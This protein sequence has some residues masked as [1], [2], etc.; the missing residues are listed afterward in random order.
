MAVAGAMAAALAPAPLSADPPRTATPVREAILD[1]SAFAEWSE[2]REAAIPADRAKNG[3]RDVVWT[4][5]Q[6]PDW[7]GVSFGL[8]RT[9]G[10]RHLRIG[11]KEAIAVGAVLSR[12]GGTLSVLKA[13]ASYPGDLANESAWLKA[14]RASGPREAVGEDYAFWTLPAGTKTRALRFSHV[15]DPTDANP[16]G[17]L[18][19]AWVLAERSANLAPQAVVTTTSRSESAGMLN[20]ESNN[21]MWPSWDNGEEGAALPVAPERPEFVTLTWPKPVKLSSLCLL[22]TGFRAADVEVFAG[23]DEQAPQNAPASSWKKAGGSDALDP[24]YPM[25]LGANWLDFAAP[26]ETRAVRLRITAGPKAEGIHGHL[27]DKLKG[28]KRIWLGEVVAVSPL[29]DAAL[30]S[31][32]PP[33]AD[34]GAPPPIPVKFTL[35]EAG[36]VTL[37]IEDKTGKRI[38]NLVSETP[39]PRGENTAWWDGSDDLLRDSSAASHGLYHIPSR[40]V[41]PGEYVVR[42]MWRKPLKLSYEASVYSA[43]K[44]PWETADKTGCW[45]TNHTPPTSVVCIPSHR[46]KEAR[47]LVF[48]GAFVAE[49]GHGLQ[50]LYEDGT[51]LGGQGWVGGHWTG[52]PTLAVDLGPKAVRDHLCYVGS[53][54]EGELRLTAKSVDFQDKPILKLSLGEDPPPDRLPKGQEKPKQLEGFDGGDRKFVLAA[55]AA[56]DGVVVCSFPRQNE[57]MFVD[58]ATGKVVRKLSLPD[59][60][61]LGFDLKGRLVAVS[62]TKVLRFP[63]EASGAAEPKGEVVPETLVATGLEDPRQI[64]LDSGDKLYV[65]DRGNSHQVKIFT[66]AGQPLRTLG[67]PGAPAAGQYDPLH[68][69]NPN[70]VAVDA[71][72]QVWIA[73]DDFHPKRVSV[74][75][76]EGRLLRTF[77][78]PGEYGGGGVLDSVD[79]AKFFYKGLEFRLD[80]KPKGVDQL[81]RVFYRPSP[82]FEAHYGPYS[83]DTP[84]YPPARF[85]RRY[86]TSC[87]THNPTNGDAVSFVWV[88]DGATARLVAAVG[89]AHEWAI[90]KT[91]PFLPLWP[92]GVDSKGDR[93]RNPAAFAWSDLN[94]DGLP[95]PDEVKMEKAECRGVTTQTDLAMVAARYNGKTVRFAP[96]GY[97][98]KGVPKYDLTKPEVLLSGAQG[99]KSSGGDQALS[100]AGGW[101]IHTVAPEPF[102]PYSLGGSFK[103]EAK[104]SY[105][106]PWPGLHASHEAAVPDRPGMVI[107][108]TRLLGGMIQP[109]KGEA[110]PL[111][112]I[113]A[114]M[115]NMYLFTA[116][117][118]FVAT[119]FHD[120]RLRP[121]WAMP[122][123][124]RGMDVSNV[125]LH[126]ENFWP[127]LTQTKEG[128]I[129]VVDGARVSLVKVDGLE[130]V[131]RIAPQPLVVSTA[132]LAQAAQWFAVEEARRQASQ[133]TGVLDVPQ[134]AD[135]PTVDG[136]LADWPAATQWASIDRRGTKA[137]FNS[138]SRPYDA[139]AAAALSGDKL[140]LAWKTNEKDL[141]RNSGETPKALFKTGGCLDLMLG[142]DPDAPADRAAP[143]AGDLR[144]LVAQVEGRTSA[145]LYRAKDPDSKDKSPVPFSSP[146]RTIHFD[147]VEDVG[148]QVQLAADG[149]GGYEVSVPL[150]VLRWKPQPG[151]SY[152]ADLGVLR[153]DGRQTTQRVYWS[154]KATAI[155]A[156]V[157]S[158]AELTPKLWG[159]FLIRQ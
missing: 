117:G 32:A 146:W 52:A 151:R 112:G 34:A 44:P 37:V 57:L 135:A 12:A 116:D 144:L 40:F 156:D 127:S 123:A 1:A 118:L 109:P 72:G 60:R 10:P 69:N 61:G 149:A 59:P 47:G 134:R 108:T 31:A 95:Q 3:P 99:P 71:L 55:I 19:G 110:G 54:W 93:H 43:G 62:G 90:L 126:D 63:A 142:T 68:M 65:S 13:D 157:P 83:P 45:M 92:A 159:L 78:G 77:Y 103:G 41:A 51:K 104:W 24:L 39:F 17:W 111:F 79:K 29:G 26:V 67:K 4:Q 102:S 8:A 98:D 88:D 42:G 107:G 14:E 147:S 152:R 56:R 120:I 128:E 82:L 80:W 49:G 53:V 76:P 97:A 30:A 94:V 129:F 18:G 105:P 89:D 139:S 158:E 140:Y 148:D 145:W 36:L 64:T 33:K 6:R 150:S 5:E 70:G 73:E 9:P 143:V 28:G 86:F 125:S 38:R 96:T 131:R 137:N 114:N 48:M 50:W 2:G 121:N 124:V 100:D 87:Y 21:R 15:A 20:D 16:A 154:N 75:S 115:G 23:P 74:W 35:P 119:L 113:N 46:T 22:W 130:T 81:V 11:F 136:K 7:K 27:T 66:A 106:N 84:L 25:G 58:V 132:D 122:T 153:G 133:G 155:T 85:G 91:E 138:D 141:L 101:T